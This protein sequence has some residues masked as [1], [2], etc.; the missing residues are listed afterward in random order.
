M[1]ATAKRLSNQAASDSRNEVTGFLGA[2]GDRIEEADKGRLLNR[3]PQPFEMGV[4]DLSQLTDEQ[5]MQQLQG[6]Q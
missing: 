2:F 1:V 3:I 5:L 6:A 4:G